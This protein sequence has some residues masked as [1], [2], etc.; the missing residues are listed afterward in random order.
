MRKGG[1]W[2]TRGLQSEGVGRRVVGSEER[3]A[4]GLEGRKGVPARGRLGAAGGP[5]PDLRCDTWV[6]TWVALGR[7]PQ[8]PRMV[9]PKKNFKK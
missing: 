4:G 3:Q 9:G 8:C 1:K 2:I 6:C 7:Q 5:G